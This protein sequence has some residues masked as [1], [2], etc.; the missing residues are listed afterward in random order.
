MTEERFRELLE[1]QAEG[2]VRDIRGD[3][4][5]DGRGG[6]FDYGYECPIRYVND[7]FGDT[8]M[9]GPDDP[10]MIGMIYMGDLGHWFYAPSGD[11]IESFTPSDEYVRA[12]APVYDFLV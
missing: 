8:L 2:I 3:L 6:E 1:A 10:A 9:L 7:R 11:T 4:E 12:F 5:A